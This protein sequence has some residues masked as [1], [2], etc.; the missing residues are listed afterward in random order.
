MDQS[1]PNNYKSNEKKY[2]R[3]V[4]SYFNTST[5]NFNSKT[6]AF[7]KFVSRQS[8]SYFLAR[9]EIFKEVIN[10][11]GNIFDFGIFK[12]SSFFTF[13]QLSAIFEPYNHLRKIVGFDSFNGFSK[14]EKED[15]SKKFNN[16]PMR[17]EGGMSLGDKA[18]DE[19]NYGIDLCNLNTPLNHIKK[20]FVIN[21]DLPYSLETYL[22]DH[23]ETII[24]MA[25]FGLGLYKPTIKILEKIKPRLVKGSIL[26][27]EDLNQETWPGETKALFEVFDMTKNELIKF[28]YCP[29]LSFF[30]I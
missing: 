18:F 6:H 29:H 8:L 22:S 2:F 12:G 7:P 10:L 19:I 30:K 20:G 26:V 14:F 27:F 11:H 28:S 1:D 24:A 15:S 23:P 13:L 4:E 5:G 3:A 9:T 16:L 25:N 17:F 21:G